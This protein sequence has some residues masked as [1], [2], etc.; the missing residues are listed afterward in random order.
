MDHRPGGGGA[1]LVTAYDAAITHRTSPCIILCMIL[2]TMAP[3]WVGLERLLR[4]RLRLSCASYDAN[5]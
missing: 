2:L 3:R 5:G 4:K 1:V